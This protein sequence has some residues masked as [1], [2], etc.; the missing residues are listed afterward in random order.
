MRPNKSKKQ[1]RWKTALT[2]VGKLK[3]WCFSHSMKSPFYH[4]CFA[5]NLFVTIQCFSSKGSFQLALL[6]SRL[7]LNK[8]N[9]ESQKITLSPNLQQLN[10][11]PGQKAAA[12]AKAKASG[13]AA[14]KPKK[15]ARAKAAAAAKVEPEEEEMQEW[16]EDD[17]NLNLDG[18]EDDS[19]DSDENINGWFWEKKTDEISTM[20]FS[21]NGWG[22]LPHG[23]NRS[24]HFSNGMCATNATHGVWPDYETV[25]LD[26][27]NLFSVHKDYKIQQCQVYQQKKNMWSQGNV[28]GVHQSVDII[29]S[30][31]CCFEWL[32]WKLC[33]KVLHWCISVLQRSCQWLISELCSK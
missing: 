19:L 11:C 22:A 15:A 12:K 25:C 24:D 29:L 5:V 13:K 10:A 8:Y 31:R 23:V 7:P 16:P 27:H 28:S 4:P 3:L 9:Y 1:W 21:V 6:I 32:T 20:Q 18:E 26:F 30:Y 14:P 17:E 2:V 33:W